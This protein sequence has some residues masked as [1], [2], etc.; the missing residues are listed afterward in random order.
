MICR[1]E[2]RSSIRTRFMEIHPLPVQQT[3]ESAQI[4]KCVCLPLQGECC[5]NREKLR[6]CNA[7]E[8]CWIEAMRKNFS[9]VSTTKSLGQ[10]VD[11]SIGSVVIKLKFGYALWKRVLNFE[12]SIC[13]VARLEAGR[14]L[15]LLTEGFVMIR[16]SEK[17]TSK[18]A[19]YGILKQAPRAWYDALINLPDFQSFTKAFSDADHAGCI[20]TRK[21]TSGGIQFLG[22]KLVKRDVKENKMHC[23]VSSAYPPMFGRVYG[24]ICSCLK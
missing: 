2:Q 9:S 18:N 5:C 14:L 8:F 7:L 21:S 22:D 12:E 10:L 17:V 13:S 19:L 23:N 20:D 15:E 4:L 6:K 11:K 3:D 1:C 24:V 16:S